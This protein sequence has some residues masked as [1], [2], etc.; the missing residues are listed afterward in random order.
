VVQ[1]FR[2]HDEEMLAEQAPHR[3]ETQRLLALTQQGR[4][5][6]EQLLTAEARSAPQVDQRDSRGDEQRGED[7]VRA[8]RL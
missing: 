2:R 8:Q 5:D 6:L 4:R 1:R 3:R 7:E